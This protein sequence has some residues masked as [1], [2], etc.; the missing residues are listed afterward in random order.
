[1][2]NATGSGKRRLIAINNSAVPRSFCADWGFNVESLVAYYHNKNAWMTGAI[3][4]DYMVKW[5]KELKDQGNNILLLMDNASCHK[6]EG[7]VELQN[8]KLAF[9]YPNV[10]SRLQ[11]L[12]QRIIANYK[13]Y[14][15]GHLAKYLRTY[16]NKLSG[17]V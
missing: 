5:D 1:M 3:F 12:D 7:G 9:F 16:I 6:I 10:T 2:C 15:K 14:Y 8:I 4:T 11:L 17:D 13:A